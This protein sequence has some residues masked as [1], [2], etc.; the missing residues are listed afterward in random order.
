MQCV[1]SKGPES[2]KKKSSSIPKGTCCWILKP[3]WKY[4]I[5]FMHAALDPWQTLTHNMLSGLGPVSP[6]VSAQP[7]LGSLSVPHAW[8]LS[9]Y[10][11]A[12]HFLNV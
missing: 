6:S 8:Y 9:A 10:L 3:G 2:K 1:F 7:L 11:D 12:T 4:M 5:Y